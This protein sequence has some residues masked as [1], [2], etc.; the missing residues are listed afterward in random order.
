MIHLS[1]GNKRVCRSLEVVS[2][3]SSRSREPVVQSHSL[4]FLRAFPTPLFLSARMETSQDLC[5]TG[6]LL[7]PASMTQTSLP[8]M[9]S[10]ARGRRHAC[11]WEHLATIS[12][13]GSP[14]QNCQHASP[15]ANPRLRA[16][17]CYPEAFSL[18][19]PPVQFVRSLFIQMMLLLHLSHR[20]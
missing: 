13:Y 5:R 10:G 4:P 3:S 19:S 14:Q 8:I 6:S 12:G 17:L 15:A 1:S 16:A 11:R 20:G 18:L 7:I 2:T 9:G